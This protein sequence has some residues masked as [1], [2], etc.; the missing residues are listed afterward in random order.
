M[1]MLKLPLAI[2]IAAIMAKRGIMAKLAI[3][4]MAIGIINIAILGIQ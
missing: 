2:T 3:L 4:E 1:A